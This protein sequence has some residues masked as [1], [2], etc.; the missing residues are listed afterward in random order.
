MA[1][2]TRPFQPEDL[3]SILDID[4]AGWQPIFASNKDIVGEKLSE[5]IH[6]DSNSRKREQVSGACLEDDPRQVCVADI[7]S[8]IVGFITVHM[9][10]D[11]KVAETG[12]NSVS[13]AH[14]HNGV[15]TKMYEFV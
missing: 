1:F 8:E 13:T 5:I 2:G 7:D 11:R 3:E 9:Y 4:V 14:H 15:G 12:N 10:H 6:A